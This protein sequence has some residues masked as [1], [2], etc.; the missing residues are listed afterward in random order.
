MLNNKYGFT[1]TDSAMACIRNL[2]YDT[3]E[4]IRLLI[5]RLKEDN[6]LDNTVLVMVSDHYM[7][8][9]SNV[10]KKKKID[11]KYLLQ[12]TPFIIWGSNIN[13]VDVDNMVDT[14]D[15]LPTV[16]NL[17]GISYDPN[18]YVGEDAFSNDRDNYIYFSSDD[19][20]DGE[21]LYSANN[22]NGDKKIYDDIDKKIRFNNSLI[23]SNYLK[24]K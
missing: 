2:V 15:I 21:K 3:D 13:H 22:G 4:M 10:N 8:G 6:K 24:L 11:N 7:Y 9:Y 12:H 20:F 5:E 23:D 14:A 17:F 1:S 18:Y 16:L 19:Y